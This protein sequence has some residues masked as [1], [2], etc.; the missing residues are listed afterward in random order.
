MSFG[1]L[2]HFGHRVLAVRIDAQER[3]AFTVIF[4]GQLGEPDAVEFAQRT[5]D[6]Q[7]RDDDKLRVL[8]LGERVR[9]AAKI[10][11]REFDRTCLPMA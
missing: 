9:L 2:G 8:Q 4:L 10:L 1:E 5:L 7:E 6:S 11:Q 3:D